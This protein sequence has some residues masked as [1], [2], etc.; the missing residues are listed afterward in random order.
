MPEAPRNRL[1]LHELANVAG[2]LT[3][4]R[5]PIAI[6]FLFVADQPGPGLALYLA[7]GWSGA[8][9]AFQLLRERGWS[10]VGPVFKGG[11]FYSIGA[12]LELSR[13]TPGLLTPHELFHFA[14]LGGV[15]WH[16]LFIHRAAGWDWVPPRQTPVVGPVTV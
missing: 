15:A 5:A 7:L 12:L 2:V 8:F 9:S 10:M 16:W 13:L 11:A 6:A 14:V 1:Q 3:V 4:A